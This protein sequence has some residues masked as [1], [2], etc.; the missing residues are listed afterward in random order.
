MNTLGS[1][2]E[3]AAYKE[4]VLYTILLLLDC[5]RLALLSYSSMALKTLM[6][7]SK[8]SKNIH[9]SFKNRDFSRPTPKSTGFRQ[10]RRST[11]VIDNTKEIRP[12]ISEGF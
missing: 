10:T 2:R 8:K 4:R 1:N 11:I 5:E 12:F 7:T 9:A 3:D 6:T